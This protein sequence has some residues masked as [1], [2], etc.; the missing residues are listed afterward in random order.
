[1]DNLFPSLM[2][3]YGEKMFQKKWGL[4]IIIHYKGLH[5]FN[6]DGM[7]VNKSLFEENGGLKK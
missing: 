6:F 1:M 2:K 4:W 3:M 7:V 5:N